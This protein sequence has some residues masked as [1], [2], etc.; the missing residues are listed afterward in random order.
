MG[1][2]GELVR[3]GRVDDCWRNGLLPF[4]DSCGD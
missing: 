3:V 4:D 2:E 1:R